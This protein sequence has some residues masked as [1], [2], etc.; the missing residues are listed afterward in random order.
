MLCMGF[1]ISLLVAD[2]EINALVCSCSLASIHR[3]YESELALNER[4]KA[5]R[6]SEIAF[7]VKKSAG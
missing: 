5:F 3:N 2:S 6:E 1:T 4:Q 7:S